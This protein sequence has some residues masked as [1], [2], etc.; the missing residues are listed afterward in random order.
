MPAVGTDFIHP[1]CPLVAVG[2]DPSLSDA[3]PVLSSSGAFTTYEWSIRDLP[4]VSAEPDMPA[5]G[6]IVPSMRAALL[7]DWEPVYDWSTSL[8]QPRSLPSAELA[9]FALELTRDASTQTE[10]A[11][12]IY[13]FVQKNIRYVA[14][15]AGVASFF[16]GYAADATWKRGWGCCID[17]AILLTAMLGA[18]GIQSYTVYLNDNTSESTQTR[19]PNLAFNHAIT[20]AL[21]DG[22]RVFLDSTGYDYRYPATADFNHG[23]PVVIPLL[24]EVAEVP[25]PQ[26]RQNG[27]FY[28]YTLSLAANGDTEI[29]AVLGYS[30]AQEAQLRGYYRECKPD[31]R[32]LALER[33]AKRLSPKASL[34][35]WRVRDFDLLEKPFTIS[36]EIQAPGYAA[37]AGPLIVLTLP[38]LEM[39]PEE[40]T[41]ASLPERKYPVQHASSIGIY[42]NYEIKIPRGLETAALP[43]KLSVLDRHFSFLLNCEQDSPERISCRAEQERKS[44]LIPA[45]DYA[46]YKAALERAAALSR[47][48]IFFRSAQ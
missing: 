48:R 1:I 2:S 16:G 34:T 37:K 17:K 27:E 13:H 40:L 14:V 7:K 44:R 11:S 28:D 36:L 29:A 31:E 33:F 9:H 43:Q 3:E 46:K 15:K 25:V 30:G 26:P 24:H 39:Q 45:E 6:D 4:P 20:L 38:D 23:A 5:P 18:C 22:K 32:K 8:L 35:D 19:I 47:S 12:I 42:R 41:E 21:I 10:K